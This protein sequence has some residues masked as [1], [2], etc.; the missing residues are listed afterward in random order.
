MI[1]SK[2]I[3]TEAE[4]LALERASE[5]KHE[6][7]NQTLLPMAGASRLHNFIA[8]HIFL[9]S[10]NFLKKTPFETYQ[11]DMRLRNPLTGSY[12]YPDVMVS[13]G[14]GQLVDD[15]YLD[16]LTNPILIIEVMSPTTAIFDKTDKFIAC[17]S[18]STLKEYVLVATDKVLVEIYRKNDD[19]TWHLYLET[20][21]N[22]SIELTSINIKIPLQEIYERVF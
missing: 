15:G 3:M 5:V 17:R 18:I 7:I 20:D 8:G 11:N 4:Y 9:L 19:E 21:M 12:F 22:A 14:K 16:T 6:F 10:F 1:L 2:T 13:D